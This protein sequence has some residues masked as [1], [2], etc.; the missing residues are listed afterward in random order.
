MSIVRHHAACA[1]FGGKIVVSGGTRWVNVT[2]N[3]VEVYDYCSNR[4]SDMPNMLEA[5]IHQ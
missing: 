3:T 5:I 2:L 1:V 4:W